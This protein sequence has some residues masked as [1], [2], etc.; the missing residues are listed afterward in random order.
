[1]SYLVMFDI[2]SGERIL[3]LKVN[4]LLK[5]IGAEKVQN[6]VWRS[7]NLQELT[8]LALWVRNSGGSAT[9]IEEKVVF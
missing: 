2:P 3:S 9:I 5:S 7:D 6:S 1:M 8:K 4:R